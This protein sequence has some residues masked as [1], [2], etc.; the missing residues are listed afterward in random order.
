M[1]VASR[2]VRLHECDCLRSGLSD[3]PSYQRVNLDVVGVLPTVQT[4]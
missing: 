2:R 1:E 3:L 4:A